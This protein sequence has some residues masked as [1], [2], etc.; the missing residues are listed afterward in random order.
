MED[1]EE[2]T[3]ERKNILVKLEKEKKLHFQRH[4]DM[5]EE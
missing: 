5:V 2:K 3:K 4:V 1:N